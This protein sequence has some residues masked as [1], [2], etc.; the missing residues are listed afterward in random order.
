MLSLVSF[1]SVLYF[2]AY[3]YCVSLGRFI[4][5][6][7][8][9]FVA[10]VNGIDSLISLSDFSLLVYRN[11]SDFFIHFSKE[12]IQVANNH[13]KRCST[14]LIIIRE[15]QIKTTMKCHLTPVRLAIIKKSTNNKCWRGC[16][17]K[18]NP[19]VL[20]VGMQIDTATMKDCMEIP[21]K[22][23]NKTTI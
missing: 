18:G 14:S 17:K 10:K 11:A 16:G 22:T 13:M 8:I 20:L 15:M 7:F 3:S 9:L 5:R 6:Y 19:L 23:R 1:I 2:P 4:P 21:L 12:Y